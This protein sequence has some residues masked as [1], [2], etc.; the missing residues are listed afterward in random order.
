[1]CIRDRSNADKLS[2]GLLPE[3]SSYLL[4]RVVR[5]AA[6][7]ANYTIDDFSISMGDIKGVAPVKKDNTNYDKIPVEV[8][9]VGPS[10]NY[11]SLVKSIER[12]LPIMSIDKLEMNSTLGD[13][14]TV[15]L[16]VS[17]YYLRE[18]TSVKL[19]NLSLADLTPSQDEINLLSKISEYKTMFLESNS[20]TKTFRIYDRSDPFSTP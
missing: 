4:V 17:A 9:L 1:M 19:E 6:A 18:L 15:K 2:L 11:L 7:E 14:S 20:E 5:N 8:T 12:S 10:G 3:K 16:E 13:V